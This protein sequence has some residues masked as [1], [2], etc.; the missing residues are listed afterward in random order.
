MAKSASEQKEKRTQRRRSRAEIRR[1]TKI[2]SKRKAKELH[3]TLRTAVKVC[4]L[5]PIQIA[6]FSGLDSS[7]VRRILKGYSE[8]T[9]MDTFVALLRVAGFKIEIVHVE[10][11]EDDFRKY[12][13]VSLPPLKED[14]Q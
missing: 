13:R 2:A 11:G 4:G 14:E 12:R 9:Q 1:S 5:T 8:S 7:T 3:A 6:D 10:P